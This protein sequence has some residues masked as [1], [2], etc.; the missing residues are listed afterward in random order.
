MSKKP[1]N[2]E[3]PSVHEDIEGFNIKI[4]EFGALET[5]IEVDK[6]NKFLNNNSEDK[7][8]QSFSEEE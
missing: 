4:N 8:L 2:S 1:S 7:K 5:N 6:L 3:K